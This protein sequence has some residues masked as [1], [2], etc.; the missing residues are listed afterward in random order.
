[1]IKGYA[2][3]GEEVLNGVLVNVSLIM[4][5]GELLG[6]PWRKT[7]LERGDRCSEYGLSVA[8]AYWQQL[9]WQ[10]IRAE[11]GGYCLP[12]RASSCNHIGR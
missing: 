1:M 9:Y 4:G 10:W 7:V 8:G 6:G 3:Y 11:L 5:H 2:L 12:N